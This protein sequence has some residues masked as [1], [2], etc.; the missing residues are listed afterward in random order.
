[1]PKFA[2]S[3]EPKVNQFQIKSKAQ[4]SK[5]ENWNDGTLEFN[6]DKKYFAFRTL[7]RFEL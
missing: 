5:K 2:R 7:S 1:M 4:M 6:V 3:D